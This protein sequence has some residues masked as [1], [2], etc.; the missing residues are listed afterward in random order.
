MIP[1]TP[2]S[3]ALIAAYLA[4]RPALKRIFVA[5]T[6][7]EAEAEDLLQDLFVRLTATASESVSNPD[8]FIYRM[9]MNQ[10]I[11]R[12][13]QQAREAARETRWSEE[14]SL[15][16]ED[17]TAEPPDLALQ[18]KQA[19]ERL[20]LAVEDLPDRTRQAFRL[21]KLEGLGHGEVARRMGIS[22]SAVEKHIM[23][24]LR[25]LMSIAEGH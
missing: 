25:R 6:G 7:S 10:L 23:R 9:G 16:G 14:R 4:R 12:R 18:R 22:R 24:A 17:S 3:S 5:R 11:D 13:R 19:M 1:K 8:A 15:S 20:T 2:S 21:H